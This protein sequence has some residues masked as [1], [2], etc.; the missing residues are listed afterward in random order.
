MAT[1][2][3][4]FMSFEAVE[5]STGFI[6]SGLAM[7]ARMSALRKLAFTAVTLTFG[8]NN[9]IRLQEELLQS[10]RSDRAMELSPE[11]LMDIAAKL[12]KIVAMNDHIVE[13][14]RHV[15]Q[16]ML[17]DALRQ[18]EAQNEQLDSLVETFRMNASSEYG[19]VIS[20]LVDSASVPHA[21]ANE[22]WRDFVA[23]LHD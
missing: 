13:A 7:A 5:E 4:P 22:S 19:K 18:I 17:R 6:S 11:G 16:L 1:M 12:E 14:G 15:S 20:D 8:L 3:V 21:A 10:L 2:C 9:Q 23:T